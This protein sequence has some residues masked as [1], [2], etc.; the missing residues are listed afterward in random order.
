MMMHC[1]KESQMS[2]H[3]GRS[4]H[5]TFLS[6]KWHK[7]YIVQKKLFKARPLQWSKRSNNITSQMI[8]RCKCIDIPRRSND[9]TFQSVKWYN[10]QDVDWLTLN[11]TQKKVISLFTS[12]WKQTLI[13]AW[14]NRPVPR[15]EVQA[16]A[17]FKA[18]FQYGKCVLIKDRRMMRWQ[19]L[20]PYRGTVHLRAFLNTQTRVK[21]W[22]CL[23]KGRI[24][25][26]CQS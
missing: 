9:K 14:E 4:S 16:A 25:L 24:M 22:W 8:S 7:G 3:T 17:S 5:K 18:S 26:A 15:K 19:Q 10:I 6:V 23:M 20:M 12:I 21:A 11:T 2:R 1:H 13:F